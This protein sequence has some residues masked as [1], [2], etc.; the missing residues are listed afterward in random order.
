MFNTHEAYRTVYPLYHLLVLMPQILK[1][2][3]VAIN[4]VFLTSAT[5]KL[6]KGF[7]PENY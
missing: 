6:T 5:M 3:L 4:Y 7:I 2:F 1:G